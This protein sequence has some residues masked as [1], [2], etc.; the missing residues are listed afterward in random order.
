VS[1]LDLEPVVGF[2]IEIRQA[3]RA[4][5]DRTEKPD[6]LSSEVDGAAAVLVNGEL[7]ACCNEYGTA[8]LVAGTEAAMTA[9]S[10]EVMVGAAMEFYAECGLV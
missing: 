8:I 3:T 1:H 4:E 7:V 9:D 5:C 10:V 2:S 6:H